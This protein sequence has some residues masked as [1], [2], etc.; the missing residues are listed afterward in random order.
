MKSCVW[1]PQCGEFYPV[2]F[3]FNLYYFLPSSTWLWRA[4][5]CAKLTARRRFGEGAWI[6]VQFNSWFSK[7]GATTAQSWK[8]PRDFWEYW[9]PISSFIR[10]KSLDVSKDHGMAEV[11]EDLWRATNSAPCSQQC[12]PE[13]GP[14]ALCLPWVNKSSHTFC[15]WIVLW[16]GQESEL[17]TGKY[18]TSVWLIG[19]IWERNQQQEGRVK[20]FPE[21]FEGGKR[22]K[23][24]KE[25]FSAIFFFS[26][27]C[28]PPSSGRF[29]L[30]LKRS[31]L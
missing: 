21:S 30:L 6:R 28:R 16:A 15:T 27:F 4:Q 18:S 3:A 9:N 19:W 26:Q 12:Q 8:T 31:C 22:K 25:L 14:R 29:S 10:V 23:Q 17:E 24:K 13:P 5:K 7:I 2:V 1:S 11:G 20:M